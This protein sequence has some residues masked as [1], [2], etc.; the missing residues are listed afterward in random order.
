MELDIEE[1]LLSLDSQDGPYRLRLPLSYPVQEEEGSARFDKSKRE[2]IITLP[3]RP[4]PAPPAPAPSSALPVSE[5]LQTSDAQSTVAEEVAACE[6]S[7]ADAAPESA[8]LPA[9]SDAAE[10]QCLSL[11]SPVFDQDESRLSIIINAHGLKEKGVKATVTD[12]TF[13]PVVVHGVT[14]DAEGYSPYI[15]R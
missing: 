7:Q 2:L 10:P 6:T 1:R 14:L 12:H 9:P 5:I 15:F 3:V 4:A 11:P 8:A 13:G